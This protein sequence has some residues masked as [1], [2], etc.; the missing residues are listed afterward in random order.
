MGNQDDRYR[1]KEE[2]NRGTNT[3]EMDAFK[4]WSTSRY[5]TSKGYKNKRR[6]QLA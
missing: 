2:T 1:K 3:L 5:S 6:K 4:N